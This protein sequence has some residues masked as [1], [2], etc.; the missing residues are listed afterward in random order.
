M[1]PLA[2]DPEAMFAAGSAVV[3]AGDGLT[4]N[5][6]V[7]TAGFAAN[8]GHDMAGE[9]FGLGYQDAA[10]SLLNAAAAAI[11]A[12]RHCGA[13][14]Q[15]G[16]ANYSHVEA[17]S[18]L[19]GGGGALQAPAEPVKITAPGPP[20][21]LGPGE[22]PP[23][24]W[25]VVQSFVD[26]VWPDGDVAGLHAAASRWRS[27]GAAASGM[28]D[29]LNA[30]KSL[31]DGQHIPEAGKIDDA[32]SQIG[33]CLGDIDGQCG[34]LASSIDSFADEVGQAQS[35]IRDLLHRLGSLANPVHGAM[36]IFEGDAIEEIK[37]IAQDINGVLHQL[38]REARGLE[39]GIK[40]V[41]QVGDG[42]VV[43]AEK[44]VRGRLVQYLGEQVGNPVA[45]VFDTWANANEGVLKGAVGMVEGL[46]DLNPQWFLVDPQGAAATWTGLG[47]TMWKGSL[48]NSFLNPEEAAQTNLQMLKSLLR[49]EDWSRDRPGLGFGENLFDVATLFAPGV[50]EAGAAADGAGAA[51]RSAEAAAA[52]GRA[53]EEAAGGLRGI[54]GARGAL[55]DISKTGGDLGANLEGVTADL[56]TIEVPGAPVGLPAGRPLEAPV[57]AT[58]HPPDAAPGTAQGPTVPSGP[59]PPNGTGPAAAGGSHEPVGAPTPAPAGAPHEPPG[60]PTVAAPEPVGGAPHE[61]LSGPVESAP[62]PAPAA[63]A[64]EPREPVSVPAEAPAAPAPA[65]GGPHDPGSVPVGSPHDPAPVSSGNPHEPLPTSVGEPRGPVPVSAP[66][67]APP[68]VAATAGDR[69]PSSLPQL[70][71]HPS[72]RAPVMPS[73]SPIEAAPVGAGAPR[74]APAPAAPSASAA[75]APHFTA[76]GGGRPAEM[77]APG[78]AWHSA[79]DGRPPDPRPPDDGGLWR[80]DDRHPR[81]KSPDGRTSDGPN[82]GEPDGQRHG[83]L[84]GDGT[85]HERETAHSVD[86]DN[87]PSEGLSAEKR[88]E[89]LAMPKGSRPDPSDYLS[90][91]Y[92]THHLGKFNDGATRFMPQSNLDKYGIAQRD[93]TSF[94]MPKN[95]ADA[96]LEAAKSNPRIMES[97]LGLPEG[98]LDSNNL[99]RIDISD[100]EE[101]NLRIPSGN[102][103]GANEQWIPGGL[104]PDGASEAVVDGGSIPPGGYNVTEIFD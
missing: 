77:P 79:G 28:R 66:V 52:A 1:A 96:M 59:T 68:A 21:T 76:P 3:A 43:K 85:P 9:V 90:A 91:E 71:E 22:P 34:T 13:L 73:G 25:E 37:K 95:E 103:A 65:V 50:G 82:D 100:P 98:F 89:I 54:A 48:V 15:Q 6:S 53:G 33:S 46:A 27:F 75:S 63:A 42:L 4:A 57:E 20:G 84:P 69:L 14:I 97:V 86:V 17:A 104:L 41:M 16:A 30:S 26:S 12:C 5:L 62:A 74:P 55:A 36:L 24:L 23:L 7:L 32:L 11:N 19:G 87:E 31:F 83:P 101:F 93:G 58:P 70:I 102:E 2:V 18:T 64:G 56:P 81:G 35:H 94:V 60:E 8:T 92:I 61:A 88:D 49:I 45:T 10:G 39:Q 29:A 78:R 80:T 72:V 99:V 67:S 44:F 40:V 38:G 51:G 47:K